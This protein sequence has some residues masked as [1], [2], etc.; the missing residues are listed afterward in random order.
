MRKFIIVIFLAMFCLLMLFPKIIYASSFLTK[1]STDKISYNQDETVRILFTIT[2]NSDSN[3]N[4]TFNSSQIYNF[5]IYQGNKAIYNWSQGRFFADVITYLKF[6]PG[7]TKAFSEKWDMKDNSGKKVGDGVYKI[8]FSIKSQSSDQIE[9]A[10]CEFTIGNVQFNPSFSDV[11]DYFISN[12][13]EILRNKGIVKGYPDGTFK[14][15]RNLSRAEAVVL[16]LRTLGYEEGALNSNTFA[17]VP[18]THWA[19]YYIEKGVELG[20]IKGKTATIF[21]PASPITRGEFVVVLVRILKFQLID[22]PSPFVDVN[23]SY[24]GYKEIVTSFNLGIVQGKEIKDAKL[25]FHPNDYITRNEAILIIGRAIS[26][27]Q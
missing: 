24:F 8:V 27:N 9:S 1:V 5:I 20:A 7:E 4:L 2:N 14:G 13:L 21:E 16:I 11:K 12:Q 22:N 6:Q 25:Y 26:F 10:S 19:F 3:I 18:K 17:D 23:K 15:E